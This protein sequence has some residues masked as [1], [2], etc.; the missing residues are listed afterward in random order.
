MRRIVVSIQNRLLSEAI[1]A[2]LREDGKFETF[3][4]LQENA[5][6]TA[7]ECE[8]FRPDILLMEVTYGC[9]ATLE[10][11]L[12]TGHRVREKLPGCKVV[13]LCDD[14]SSPDIANRVKEARYKEFIDAFFY[15]SVSSAYLKAVLES[16]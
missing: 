16:I 3:E 5:G 14:N 8:I 10:K 6:K 15:A 9:E 2:T 12:E 7:E 4:I 11:R 13:L 1:C